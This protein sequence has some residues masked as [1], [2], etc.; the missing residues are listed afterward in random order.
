[1]K[2]NKW[3]LISAILG[4]VTSVLFILAGAFNTIT[5]AKGLFYVAGVCLLISSSGFYY[6]YVKNKIS[7]KDR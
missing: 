2:N 7:E 3:Y 6:T 5:L 1:M 4:M